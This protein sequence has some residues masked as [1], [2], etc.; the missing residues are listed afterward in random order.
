MW[1]GIYKFIT[2]AHSLDTGLEKVQRITIYAEA[3]T[4]RIPEIKMN[5]NIK[6]KP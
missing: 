5:N 6:Y 2:H 3:L 4:K 1:S